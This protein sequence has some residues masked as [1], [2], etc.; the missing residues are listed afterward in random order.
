[1]ATKRRTPKVEKSALNFT[2]NQKS[3][4]SLN[5]IFKREPNEKKYTQ[6]IVSIDLFPGSSIQREI[7][8]AVKR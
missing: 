5:F 3:R 4:T 7:L 1:M 2:L 8:S 6:L